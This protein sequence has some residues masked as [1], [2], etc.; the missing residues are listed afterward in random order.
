MRRRDGGVEVSRALLLGAGNNRKL[1]MGVGN[2]PAPETVIT[3]DMDV[4]SRPDIVWDLENK[5]W[6]IEG[7]SFDQIH[8]YEVLEH[9]GRQGDW[10]G[11]FDDFAEIY[12]ILK[13][14][15][16]LVFSC[17][18]PES[19]WAWGDPGHTRIVSLESLTFLDQDNYAQVGTTPMTDYRDYWKGNLKY[20]A[21][22]KTEHN[23]FA[24]LQAVK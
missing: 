16:Y 2:I 13:P 23:L 11:F 21:H 6:P 4:N 24:I 7:N 17:P 1:K 14:G 18:L 10:R 3:L 19:V 22:Q 15:G 20:V 5:P 12:R 8:A 9:L